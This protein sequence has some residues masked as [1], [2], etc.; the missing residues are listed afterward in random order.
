M[1]IRSPKLYDNF[2]VLDKRISED[3]TLSWAARGLLVFLLG[4]PDHW[5]VS[6][7]HL[8][9]QTLKSAKPTK[10]D[11]IYSLLNELI[12]SGYV[13]RVASNNNGRFGSVNYIVSEWPDIENIEVITKPAKLPLTDKTE[14]VNAPL[15]PLP[16][17]ALPDT[18]NTPQVRTEYKQEL[19]E[20]ERI[21]KDISTQ[22]VLPDWVSKEKWNLWMK[23]RKGKKMIPAQMQAQID[24]MGRWKAAGLDYQKS[25]A[26]AADN[27]YQGLVEPRQPQQSYSPKQPAQRPVYEYTPSDQVFEGFKIIE[28]EVLR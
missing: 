15:T 21:E 22:F 16:D 24:K 11:G 4:K 12:A 19:K 7:A 28:G 2:Y 26:D 25:L 27:G 3:E 20:Q 10:R 23:T 6:V 9:S 14:T 8:Q 1:I 5:E 13:K 18:A 17:T